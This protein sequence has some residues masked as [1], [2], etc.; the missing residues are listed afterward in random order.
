MSEGK[1][2]QSRF[3]FWVLGVQKLFIHTLE[4]ADQTIANFSMLYEL[5]TPQKW[6][7]NIFADF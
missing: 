2:N 7:K 6:R 5:Q 4:V 3:E 1:K